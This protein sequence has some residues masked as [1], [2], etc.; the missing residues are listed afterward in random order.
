M[1]QEE[2]FIVLVAGY[3]NYTK[4]YPS[5][6]KRFGKENYAYT[7]NV[8]RYTVDE[9]LDEI[10]SIIPKNREYMLIGYSMGASLIIEL[11]NREII[12]NCKGVTLIGGSRYQPTHWF[13][14]FVF[15]LPVPFIYFF[16]SILLFAYPFVLIFTGFN[17]EKARH[18]CFEGFQS[19]LE[20][21]AK[22]MKK[23]YNQ[24]IRTV[25][26]DINGIMEENKDIPTLII[27]LKEDLMVDEEDLE[28]TRT[29]FNKTK[30]IIMPAD[31]IHLTHAM[32]AEFVDIFMSEREFF[33]L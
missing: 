27:R 17:F 30:E 23:E 1:T 25:G 15:S 13:L 24:C 12:E 26:L 11:L 8:N 3:S 18:S 20:Y 28:Y 5:Y 4:Q 32:D 19:L 29:F 16:A 6:E 21:K 22:E 7:T 9:H 10:R 14:N 31:I 33:D 2:P